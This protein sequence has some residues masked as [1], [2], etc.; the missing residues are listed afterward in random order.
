MQV[1]HWQLPSN[2]IAGK[3]P[4]SLKIITGLLSSGPPLFTLWAL[5]KRAT[6]HDSSGQGI[7]M[8]HCL[9]HHPPN[10][11]RCKSQHIILYCGIN[12]IHYAAVLRKQKLG[13]P[14]GLRSRP[15]RSSALT[16]PQP[17]FY[18]L[19]LQPRPNNSSNAG[20]VRCMRTKPQTRLVPR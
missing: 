9:G 1:S 16:I 15:H 3:M 6:V 8:R 12:N 5:E 19:I 7:R 14:L 18:R 10:S 20:S 4:K 13:L 17:L 2:L 11:N